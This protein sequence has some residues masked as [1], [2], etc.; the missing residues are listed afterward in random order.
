MRPLDAIAQ[1]GAL[2]TL[3]RDVAE[4]RAALEHAT[5]AL[6]TLAIHPDGLIA[7]AHEA[8]ESVAR[9]PRYAEVLA[10][11]THCAARQQLTGGLIAAEVE[12]ECALMLAIVCND[13]G[14]FTETLALC[15]QV[16]ESE[17]SLSRHTHGWRAQLERAVAHNG[18]GSLS[19]A[20]QALAQARA[21]QDPADPIADA[22][23]QRVAGQLAL[24]GNRYDEA[25]EHLSAA[26]R[27][28]L[29][30]GRAGEA[31]R[32]W[33]E[34]GYT[35]LYLDAQRAWPILTEARDRF[36]ALGLPLDLTLT[37]Y[38]LALAYQRLNRYEDA[39]NLQR[40]CA[41]TFLAYRAP[42]F[43]AHCQ[44]EIGLLLVRLDRFDEADR[45]LQEA[46]ALFV[47]Q[48][49]LAEAIRCEINL[50]LLYKE[51]QR[52]WDALP[53]L[54]RAA[55]HAL[56]S[57]RLVRA[58]RC[59]ENLAAVYRQ[60]GQYD[61]SLSACL[62]AR[63]VYAG[64]QLLD[65]VATCDE[66]LGST[67]L[68]LSMHDQAS[69][70]YE[71]ARA[72]YRQSRQELFL[73]RCEIRL[74]ELNMTQAKWEQAQALLQHARAVCAAR[75]LPVQ[76]AECDRLLAE[77]ALRQGVLAEA[78]THLAAAR[79]TF[80]TQG[81]TGQ[82]ARCDLL[83]GE[84]QLARG[85]LAQAEQSFARAEQTLGPLI[86]DEAWRAAEGLARSALQRGE[87]HLALSHF[88]RGLRLIQSVRAPLPS[89]RLS[90]AY[91]SGRSPLLDSAFQVAFAA[92][93]WAEALSIGEAA[94]TTTF[95]RFLQ[96]R[97][98]AL[99]A[100]VNADPHIAVLLA[101][102]ARLKRE[103]T[104]LHRQF[105]LTG[106]LTTPQ[107]FE[108]FLRG[109]ATPSDGA[110]LEHYQ[111][112]AQAYEETVEQLRLLAMTGFAE[113]A[114]EPFSLS[115]L[116]RALSERLGEGWLCLAYH[117]MG[118]TVYIFTITPQQLSCQPQPLGRLAQ[119][120]LRQCTSHEPDMRELIYRGT[121]G[122][123]ATGSTLGQKHL[124]QLCE[125]L[126]PESVRQHLERLDLLIV[127]PAGRL[128]G[129][130]FHALLDGDRY[131]IERAPVLYS[132]SLHA[133]QTLAARPS[134]EAANVPALLC[135]L[136][137]FG[138][139][140]RALPHAQ[141]EVEA[142]AAILGSRA[143]AWWAEAATADALRQ[144][145]ESGE[146]AR[147]GLIHFATH[148]LVSPYSPWQSRI[149]L[150]ES[151]LTVADILDLHL[152][153]ALVTLSVC[154]SASGEATSGDEWLNLARAFFYAGAHRLVASQ[155][156]VEDRETQ[157]L[158]SEFYGQ[159][160]SGWQPA[161]ALQQAQ[162]TLL[163]QRMP[164]YQWAAFNMIG[165]P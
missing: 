149:L 150:H 75:E 161:R 113:R 93:Q 91:F 24:F 160:L 7:A 22:Y 118:D 35:M 125:L 158:M 106:Q 52:S 67:Y 4:G 41:Q 13:L 157:R 124:R 105:D 45:Q 146:L 30:L 141:R 38:I 37:D 138:E 44:S 92:Q 73:A 33:R 68:R 25:Y 48:H 108:T 65:D 129:L 120:A 136:R 8:R 145:S 82:V 69:A 88:M 78:Q 58:A 63:H 95:S 80:E 123:Q 164:P 126:I 144:S 116:Q 139:R 79:V 42:W 110:W 122:G 11:L 86:P 109:Q 87:R 62:R 107:K 74:A 49:A 117:L 130:P 47:Q 43:V 132:P 133:L 128:H 103:L 121:L 94:K 15:A 66:D 89:E 17:A 72:Y 10:R 112:L 162:I 163:R 77:A 135:G 114:S 131:L 36:V 165:R 3:A 159:L 18:L 1:L 59:F 21:A 134:P 29:A 53:L 84:W 102:E 56:A 127:I 81:L 156:P 16:L 31:A 97:A 154:Q 101:E 23:T 39:L 19:E 6:P 90:A 27:L 26:H 12:T 5:A 46:R 32:A 111:A 20:R 85:A 54:Q 57:G 137:D 71:R 61:Q 55:E 155:W 76:V 9:E 142:L 99:R 140:A 104:A 34:M 151:E 51:M 40:Q 100:N 83:D 143:Q 153:G 98:H 2:R 70:A 60:Q 119:S 148:G 50:G 147:Y 64:Q 28:F 14:H 152:G 115:A 96:Q